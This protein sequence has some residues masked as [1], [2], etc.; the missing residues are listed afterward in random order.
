MSVGSQ[1][2]IGLTLLYIAFSQIFWGMY[3]FTAF[4]PAG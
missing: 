3:Q 4:G 2:K 1:G